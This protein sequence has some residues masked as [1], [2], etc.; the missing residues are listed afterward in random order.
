[1]SRLNVIQTA[2]RGVYRNSP[3]GTILYCARS[4]NT[5]WETLKKTGEDPDWGSGFEHEIH[6]L[7][8]NYFPGGSTA[9]VAA[10][11]VIKAVEAM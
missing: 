4:I 7:I 8:W 6:M 11:K 1:M 3:T 9:Q 5:G 10:Q 2:L